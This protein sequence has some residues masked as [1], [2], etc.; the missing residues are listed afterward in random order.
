MV[1]CGAVHLQ[2]AEEVVSELVVI[3]KESRNSEYEAVAF[4]VTDENEQVR[5]QRHPATAIL[6]GRHRIRLSNTASSDSE[7]RARASVRL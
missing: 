5:E 4:S 2:V 6:G 1:E 7:Q 3:L